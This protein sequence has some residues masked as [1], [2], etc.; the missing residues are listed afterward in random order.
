MIGVLLVSH[1]KM[2]EGIKDSVGMIVGD[3]GQFDTLALI[4]GQDIANL[5]TDILAKTKALN[6]GDGVL[7][8]VDLFGASPYNASM[9]CLPEWDKLN[10]QTRVV[11][12]M[13]LPMVI[14]AVCNRDFSSLEELAQD[15]INA[16]I[17]NMKDA[18]AELQAANSSASDGD[19]Y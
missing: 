15:S 13:S 8:F 18:V 16:G 11:T 3:I 19:D 10:I 4:P 9:K 2:A 12:G 1:G 14:T 6:S 7:I 5:G 17:E